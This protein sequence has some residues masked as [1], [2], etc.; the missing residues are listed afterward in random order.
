M[1]DTLPSPL[2]C[3][4]GWKVDVLDAILDHAYQRKLVRA[5]EKKDRGSLDFN[6]FAAPSERAS[7]DFNVR[8]K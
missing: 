7:W 8:K 3:P 6:N 2:P 4:D 1:G 5:V